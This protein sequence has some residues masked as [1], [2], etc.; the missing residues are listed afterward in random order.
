MRTDVKVRA[1]LPDYELADHTGQPQRLSGPND[2]PEARSW[3]RALRGC[4]VRAQPRA[5]LG[6][7]VYDGPAGRL[8]SLSARMRVSPLAPHSPLLWRRGRLLAW[9]GR[10]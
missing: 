8:L 9:R 6:P 2:G 3:P 1:P 10:R 5:S 4:R 7:E